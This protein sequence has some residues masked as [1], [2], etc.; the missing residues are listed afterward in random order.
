MSESEPDAIFKRLSCP[1][2]PAGFAIYITLVL[3]PHP[4]RLITAEELFRGTLTQT[5]VY[6][7]EVVKH[8][9]NHNAAAVIHAH[10]HPSGQSQPS[11]ADI[12]L[13]RGLKDALALVDVKLLDH[14][15]VTAT[16]NPFSLAENG[17]L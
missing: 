9:L 5:S 10:H 6:P 13:T 12:T 14:F 3:T 4:H 17:L 7:R 8:A 16:G 11:A 15:I 1:G 2:Y